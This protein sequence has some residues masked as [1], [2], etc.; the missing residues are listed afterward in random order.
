MPRMPFDKLMELLKGAAWVIGAIVALFLWGAR[1]EFQV[2]Q[3]AGRE[4]VR[5]ELQSHERVLDRIDARTAR[6]DSLVIRM[7]CR[8]TPNDTACPRR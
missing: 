3:K 5:A 6:T 2:A 4:E 7:V 1:L 8:Q